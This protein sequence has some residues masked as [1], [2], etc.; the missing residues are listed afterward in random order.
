MPLTLLTFQLYSLITGYSGTWHVCINFKVG[1]NE[2]WERGMHHVYS[3]A[4]MCH[5]SSKL[6]TK[7]K[8]TL[9]NPSITLAYNA[10]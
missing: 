5:K 6:Y 7:G 9:M 2:N 1:L 8:I 10:W 4:V 3:I